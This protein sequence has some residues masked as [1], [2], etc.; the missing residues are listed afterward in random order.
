MVR[1]L[2]IS[3][4]DTN[5]TKWLSKCEGSLHKSKSKRQLYG[6]HDGRRCEIKEQGKETK[7]NCRMETRKP[8][9]EHDIKSKNG[10]KVE[11]QMKEGENLCDGFEKWNTPLGV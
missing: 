5:L 4:L 3:P 7:Q 10:M 6:E 9:Q 11:E 1:T 2:R 8:K